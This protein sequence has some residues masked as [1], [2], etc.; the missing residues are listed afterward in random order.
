MQANATSQ[1]L[2]GG[3]GTMGGVASQR[4]GGIFSKNTLEAPFKCMASAG[5]V[6]PLMLPEGFNTEQEGTLTALVTSD[7]YSRDKSCKTIPAGSIFHGYYKTEVSR[8]QARASL[9]FSAIER[10]PPLGDT[11]MLDGAKAYER[12]GRAGLTGDVNANI[13][14]GMII[15]STIIDIGAQALGSLDGGT[16]INIGGAVANNAGSVLRDV[17]RDRYQKAPPSIDVGPKAIS[18]RL[19]KHLEMVPFPE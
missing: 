13:P 9:T 8:G 19:D 15:A 1:E 10:P 7:S 14:W 3:G 5:T 12:D 4:R 18:V 16:D 17:A 2:A 11:I 6:V